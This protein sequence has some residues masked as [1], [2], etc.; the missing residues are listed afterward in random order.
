MT[1]LVIP[2]GAICACEQNKWQRHQ[3]DRGQLVRCADCGFIAA[4]ADDASE[5]PALFTVTLTL[6]SLCLRGEGG[7]CHSPGCALWMKSAPDCP[8]YLEGPR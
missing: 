8:L 5:S 6:C 7:E 1:P 3:G 4:I 2:P